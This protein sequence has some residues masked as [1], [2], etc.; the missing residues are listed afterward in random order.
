MTDP[1]RATSRRRF[2]TMAGAAGASAALLRVMTGHAPASAAPGWV[3]AQ[4]LPRGTG[5]GQTVLILG[6]GIAGLTAA[7]ELSRAGYD[8]LIL[9]AQQRAGGRSLTVRRGDRVTELTREG[10]VSQE[11]RFDEGLYLNLGPGRLPHHHRRVLRYCRELG[12]ALEPYLAETTANLVQTPTGFDGAPRTFRQVANDTR[13]RIAELL[14]TVINNGGLADEL[15]GEDRDLARSLLRSFGSLSADDTYQGSTRSGCEDP[16]TVYRGCEPP[17]PLTMPELLD[18][19]FW[20]TNFYQPIE[21]LWQPTLFQPVGGMDM[22]VKG[23]VEKVGSLIRYGA[24]A[25]DIDIAEDSVAVTWREGDR[26]FTRQADYCLSNIPL[27]L[28]QGIPANFSDGFGDAVHFVT[29][30]PACKVGW[31]ANSRFWESDRYEIYGGISRIRHNINQM[32]Y[33]SY[34]YFTDKGTMTGAYNYETDAQE[35]GEMSLADRLKTAKEGGARLHPEF[36]DETIVPTELGLSIAWQNVPYQQ[37][38]WARWRDEEEYRQAYGRLLDPD[39]RFHVI[40]DQV[41]PLDG[42][43]EGAMMSAEHVINQVAGL[44]PL[45]EGAA[46]AHAPDSRSLTQGDAA[47]RA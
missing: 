41:S 40:G 37:G 20:Q 5:T 45:T 4:Q 6:A 3:G 42:W 31:Q 22:I 36:D 17:A 35:L 14:A 24:V 19:R 32:W 13:G 47:L 8:C 12:V 28:L 26:V 18:S 7:H 16:L 21:Y 15:I 10:V 27:P 29:Y 43:Q 44:V 34:D 1:A 38:G 9:E 46:V 23:F 25:T 33:P 39:R 11:C 2:L 30:E